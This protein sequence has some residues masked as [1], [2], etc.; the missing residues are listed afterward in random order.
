VGERCQSIQGRGKKEQ[1]RE[2]RILGN[3]R[4]GGV[5][6]VLAWTYDSLYVV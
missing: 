1:V 6:E 4:T 3:E 5:N 2:R